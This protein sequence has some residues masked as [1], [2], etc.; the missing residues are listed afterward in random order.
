MSVTPRGIRNNNPGNIRKGA[1][2]QGLAPEQNDPAFCNFSS[3][4]W[5]IRAMGKILLKYQ[6]SYHLNTIEKIIDRW[7]PPVENQTSEYVAAVARDM[8]IAATTPIDVGK[9]A[10]LV[11]LIR[12]IIHHENGR[13]PYD[14]DT[15]ERGA[16]LALAG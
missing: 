14:A 12:A 1:D 3:P 13:Q 9:L 8:G 6:R 5:G 4:E 16:K 10:T 7:A 15:L 11:P 2:W